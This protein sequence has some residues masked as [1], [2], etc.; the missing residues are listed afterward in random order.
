MGIKQS[1][2]K[3]AVIVAC[4]V[5]TFQIITIPAAADTSK[6]SSYLWEMFA[7]E[8]TD[9]VED[10]AIPRARGD[11]LNK[12][13]IRLSNVDGKAS[14]Y[15]ETLGNYLSDEIC[16]ELYLEKYNGTK[17]VSYDDW[18][19]VEHNVYYVDASLTVTVPKGYYYSLRGYHY[20]SDNGMFEAVS[21]MTDGLQIK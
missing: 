3:L 1:L 18:S 7:D 14:V 15:G 4:G 8:D 21:T 17:F 2:K 13:Y 16:L 10:T 5:C 19:Y 11:V 6:T 12:G 9:T 20:V